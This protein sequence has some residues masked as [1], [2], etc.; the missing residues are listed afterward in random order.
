MES[1]QAPFRRSIFITGAGS[2]IG[3]AVALRFAR[4]GWL[5]GCIDRNMGALDAL[6]RGLGADCSWCR[7]VDV[8]DRPALLEA[9][10][11]FATVSSCAPSCT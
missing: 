10:G 2:G 7:T 9:L 4:A 5:V 1:N 6:L 8:T 3:R 11:A